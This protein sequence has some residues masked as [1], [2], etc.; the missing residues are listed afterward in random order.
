MDW[1]SKKCFPNSGVK[2]REN[3]FSFGPVVGSVIGAADLD[4]GSEA[5]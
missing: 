3:C 1:G 5:I 2:F 4:G